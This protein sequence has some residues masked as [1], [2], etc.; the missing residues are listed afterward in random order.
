M[1]SSLEE[2]LQLPL[3]LSV[4]PLILVQEGEKAISS[5]IV[6]HVTLSWR[7]KEGGTLVPPAQTM[8]AVFHVGS[9]ERTPAVAVVCGVAIS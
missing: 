8:S 6:R 7:M 5:G 4:F 2:F 1:A 3:P 9:S